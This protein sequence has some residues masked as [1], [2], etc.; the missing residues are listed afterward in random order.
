MNNKPL[1]TIVTSCY[2]H[3]EFL[4]DYFQS[5]INQTYENIELILFDDESKD[6]SQTIIEEWLPILKKRFVRVVYIPR[7]KN[8][9]VVVNC[10]KGLELVLGKYVCF[11]ASDDIM[12]PKKVEENVCFLEENSKYGMVYSN[13]LLLKKEKI[14][15]KPM[16][17]KEMPSGDIFVDLLIKNNYIPALSVCIRK[18][19]FNIVGNYDESLNAEDYQMWIK[20][21]EKYQVGYIHKPLAIYR[22]NPNSLC[23]SREY[24]LEGMSSWLSFKRSFFKSTKVNEKII[25]EVLKTTYANYARRSFYFNDM[26]KFKEYY[27]NYM[28]LSS[29]NSYLNFKL[30]FLN[31]IAKFSGLYKTIIII[32]YI[33]RYSKFTSINTLNRK[34]KELMKQKI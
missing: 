27:S 34:I 5:I 2:N 10:N 4:K 26:K 22:L 33:C 14:T 12:L 17:D 31:F 30:K 16:F 19:V 21:S 28:K 23:N 20:I 25:Q 9:G 32:A 18:N 3:E 6:K 15:R 13:V 11:F 8:V 1:V 24:K 7:K 29:K